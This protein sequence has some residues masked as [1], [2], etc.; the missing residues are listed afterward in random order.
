MRWSAPTFL[1][2][3]GHCVDAAA[4]TGGSQRL[5]AAQD[6]MQGW[7]A[8]GSYVSAPTKELRR[9]QLDISAPAI[10]PAVHPNPSRSLQCS[11]VSVLALSWRLKFIEEDLQPLLLGSGQH[12][13]G[14]WQG[15]HSAIWVLS[16][17]WPTCSMS[18]LISSERAGGAK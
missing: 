15:V 11:L 2:S 3:D 14:G 6:G 7:T 18:Y 4:R 17:R 13:H 8:S 10:L 12:L 16:W 1:H 5:P 9:I